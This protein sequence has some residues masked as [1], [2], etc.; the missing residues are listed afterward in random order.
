MLVAGNT[1]AARFVTTGSSIG[2][3]NYESRRRRGA[4]GGGILGTLP[5][6]QLAVGLER[7]KPGW[8]VGEGSV[9][10]VVVVG[11]ILDSLQGLGRMVPGHSFHPEYSRSN[12]ANVV[13]L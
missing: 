4:V 7:L 5:T 8:L 1:S 9:V 6:V 11:V 13:V 10:V 3:A 12:R 2:C